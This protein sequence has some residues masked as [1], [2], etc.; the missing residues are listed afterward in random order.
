[1]GKLNNDIQALSDNCKWYNIY[2]VRI[3]NEE[4][5]EKHQKHLQLQHLKSFQNE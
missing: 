2:L 1:M 4:E 3:L 5:K